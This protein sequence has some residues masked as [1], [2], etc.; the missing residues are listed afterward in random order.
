M[1]GEGFE[2]DPDSGTTSNPLADAFQGL[3][4]GWSLVKDA[5][6][7]DKREG[8]PGWN[9][10]GKLRTVCSK[11]ETPLVMGSQLKEHKLCV[12]CEITGGTQTTKEQYKKG[13]TH[14]V[15]QEEYDREK[16]KAGGIIHP[17]GKDKEAR[18]LK[19]IHDRKYG[20]DGRLITTKRGGA[21][22]RPV[23]MTRKQ[24]DDD[25]DTDNIRWD[26]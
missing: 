17:E 2:Y 1:L 9:V 12:M 6:S 8:T 13:M 20:R 25:Y 15:D 10:T 18:A 24:Q 26:D 14:F 22:R 23:R 5:M 21:F 11:C 19:Q 3:E 16:R 4:I 7:Q